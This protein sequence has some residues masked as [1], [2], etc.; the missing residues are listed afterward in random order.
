MQIKPNKI[1][2]IL[3]LI[4]SIDTLGSIVAIAV[5]KDSNFIGNMIH[6]KTNNTKPKPALVT[7]T[8]DEI[9]LVNSFLISEGITL[10][11]LIL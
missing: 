11:V 2:G 1:T 3:D 5:V 6:P 9:N 4:V 8:G 10:F 7:K